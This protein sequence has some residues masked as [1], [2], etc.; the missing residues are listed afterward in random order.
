MLS[1]VLGRAHLGGDVAHVLLVALDEL[2]VSLEPRD[3]VLHTVEQRLGPSALRLARLLYV[4]YR[5]LL[6]IPARAR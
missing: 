2:Q 6:V 5:V 1:Y 3:A 4:L